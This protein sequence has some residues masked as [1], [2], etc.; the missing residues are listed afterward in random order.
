MELWKELANEAGKLFFRLF[1]FE[2]GKFVSC[3]ACCNL[4]V[5]AREVRVRL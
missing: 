2:L 4:V 3:F 5:S 1:S